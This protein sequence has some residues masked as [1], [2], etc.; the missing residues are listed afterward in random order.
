MYRVCEHTFKHQTSK[1]RV[2]FSV[3]MD[4]YVVTKEEFGDGYWT[5]ISLSNLHW[6]D[7]QFFPF[8]PFVKHLPWECREWWST[9]STNPSHT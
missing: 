1:R 6:S 2:T 3:C 9:S 5:P 8:P 4:Q 7:Y